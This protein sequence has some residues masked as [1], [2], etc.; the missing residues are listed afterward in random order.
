MTE[1]QIA[2]AGSLVCFLLI[3][4][5]FQY[6]RKYALIHL[7]SFG[8]Y[9]IFLYYGLEYKSEGG[10]GL[11]WWFYLI[12]LTSIQTIILATHIIIKLFKNKRPFDKNKD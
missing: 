5:L 4:Y 1:Y 9:S 7:I 12:V 2:Y 11:V 6:N 3:I 10:S 8:V